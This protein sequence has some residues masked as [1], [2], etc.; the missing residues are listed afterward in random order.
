MDE[1]QQVGFTLT[2]LLQEH[3]MMSQESHDYLQQ[4]N[5]DYH[6]WVEQEYDKLRDELKVLNEMNYKEAM[7]LLE[8]TYKQ[9]ST[10]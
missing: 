8:D 3:E 6:T 5:K 7:K 9:N 4:K 2:Y 10:P 1:R